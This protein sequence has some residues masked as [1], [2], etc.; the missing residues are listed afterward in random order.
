MTRQRS[1]LEM[2][3]WGKR[4]NISTTVVLNSPTDLSNGLAIG[5][6]GEWTTLLRLS[7][8]HAESVK[9]WLRPIQMLVVTLRMSYVPRIPGLIGPP[10][11]ALTASPSIL[12]L[13]LPTYTFNLTPSR[14]GSLIRMPG[15][16]H[17]GPRSARCVVH[18][19]VPAFISAP[20]P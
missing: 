9:Q 11:V 4:L 1:L 16:R 17:Y 12:C 3:I 5:Q 8:E 2:V 14:T 20:V 15:C 10:I 19:Y 6:T 18:V 13:V 7:K